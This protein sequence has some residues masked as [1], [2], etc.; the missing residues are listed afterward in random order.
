MTSATETKATAKVR[1]VKRRS[2]DQPTNLNFIWVWWTGDRKQTD[3]DSITAVGY[4]SRGTASGASGR[5]VDVQ[6]TVGALALHSQGST[7]DEE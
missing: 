1:S 2:K 5:G 7:G 6:R 3:R 4:A